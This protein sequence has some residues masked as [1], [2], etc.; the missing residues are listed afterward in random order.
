M[1]K[2]HEKTKE[3]FYKPIQPIEEWPIHKMSQNRDAFIQSVTK[4]SIQIVNQKT[5]NDPVKLREAMAKVLYNE[6]SRLIQEPWRVD[7]P[8]EKDFWKKVHQTILQGATQIAPDR[9]TDAESQTFQTIISRYCNEIAGNFRPG[10]YRTATRFVPMGVNRLLNTISSRKIWNPNVNPPDRLRWIGNVEHIR[11]LT[12]K[13]T[14]IL[15]PTHFSNLDSIIIGWA[16]H[17]LG[18]PAFL[19]GAGL[20]LFN[21]RI[22]AYFMS[23]LGAYTIDRRKKNPFYLESLKTYSRKS[24][25]YGAHSLFFPGGTRSRSGQI[26]TRLKLGILGSA[27][28]AQRMNFMQPN[29]MKYAKNAEEKI[30]IVPLVLNYHFVLE[31]ASLIEQY[32]KSSGKELYY[33][34][35]GTFPDGIKGFTN[36]MLQFASAKSEIVLSFAPPMDI[37]GNPIDAEGNSIG[38]NGEQLDISAYFVSNGQIKEDRQRDA[39]YTRLLS[40]KIIEKFYQYNNVLSSHLVAFAGFELLNRKHR[41]LDLYGLLRL[42]E[43]DRVIPY[44]QFATFV[45]RLRDELKKMASRGE[46]RLAAHAHGDIDRL[47]KHGIRHLGVY[48][49]KDP[50]KRIEN[51]DVTCEDMNLLFYYHNRL[52]GY[53][54][55]NKV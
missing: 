38:K 9:L 48:H 44:Q 45:E 32:L 4:E 42:P 21:T 7:P 50:L 47:I 29:R 26:E 24:I 13:G 15:V 51:G 1:S 17:M 36:F 18:L 35:K 19:Y 43:E 40:E 37:F 6:R 10:T 34:D 31:A 8:D 30:F 2:L 53:E 25:Q 12:L 39:E 5:S 46:V 11:E 41:R 54:L 33:V 22:L 16:I 52:K 55:E 27:V 49:T 14:V 28:E 20:N 3:G 23:K